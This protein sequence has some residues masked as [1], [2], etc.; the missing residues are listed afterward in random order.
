MF[1]EFVEIVKAIQYQGQIQKRTQRDQTLAFKSLQRTPGHARACRQFSLRQVHGKTPC[2]KPHCNSG[3]YLLHRLEINSQYIA[4][5]YILYDIIVEILP[6]HIKRSYNQLPVFLAGWRLLYP[7]IASGKRTLAQGV[8]DTTGNIKVAQQ[9]L[10]HA[11]LGTTADRYIRVDQHAM[12]SALAAV[13]T[14]AER[15]AAQRTWP[16]RKAAQ[17]AFSYDDQTIAELERTI[18]QA[19][20]LE[21]AEEAS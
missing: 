17:Y 21:S 20:G 5:S 8:L 6:I 3:L 19:S 12:V 4:Y 16:S 9:I 1:G 2:L 13:K 18:G 11:H 15:R 14:G 10:G 7:Q